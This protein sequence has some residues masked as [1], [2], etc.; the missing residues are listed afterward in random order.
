MFGGCASVSWHFD[1]VGPVVTDDVVAESQAAAHSA[2]IAT[3][4]T[5]A[6]EYLKDID[7]RAQ[8]SRA[9]L[10]CA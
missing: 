10:L 3:I 8:I 4:G 5:S 7:I 2:T 9:V 1:G 6:G